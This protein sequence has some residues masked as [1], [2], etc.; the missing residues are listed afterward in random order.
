[1]LT[2]MRIKYCTCRY[3]Q[4][5]RRTKNRNHLQ[6]C[7]SSQVGENL[8]Y[9]RKNTLND[10]DGNSKGYFR[11]DVIDSRKFRFYEKK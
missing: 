10:S 5:K 1:L 7:S 6:G 8:G 11:K 3:L 4:E 2:P 9:N